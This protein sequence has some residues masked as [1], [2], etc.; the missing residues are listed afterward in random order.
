MQLSMHVHWFL[1]LPFYFTEFYILE[2]NSVLKEAV[3]MRKKLR[4]ETRM[5]HIDDYGKYT[6]KFWKRQYIFSNSIFNS[7]FKRLAFNVLL[8]S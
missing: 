8:F 4:T 6:R 2:S 3:S 5:L 7:S 1:S